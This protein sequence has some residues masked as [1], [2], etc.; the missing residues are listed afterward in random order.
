MSLP[1]P[2]RIGRASV[3]LIAALAVAG[4]SA[5]FAV[6]PADAVTRYRNQLRWVVVDCSFTQIGALHSRI[7]T[8]I[9]QYE[10]TYVW[11]S[12]EH[13]ARRAAD[14]VDVRG[15][16]KCRIDPLDPTS[17]THGE[18]PPTFPWLAFVPSLVGVTLLALA[19]F[20]ARD[21]QGSRP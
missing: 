21:S 16:T 11:R 7:G 14:L 12:V 13:R 9:K 15:K 18:R 20:L 10:L 17:A 19:G 4:L 2:E 5:L 1:G 3:F 6:S 8:E